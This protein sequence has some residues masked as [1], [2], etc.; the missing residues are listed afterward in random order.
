MA[1]PT[2]SSLAQK[3][4]VIH[5]QKKGLCPAA[6]RHASM[7]LASCTAQN[8]QGRAVPLMAEPEAGATRCSLVSAAKIIAVIVQWP[9]HVRLLSDPLDCSPPGSSDNGI[10]Q[11]RILEW[12]AISFSRDLPDPGMEP[13]FPALAGS[14]FT[15]K[16][17]GR[18]CRQG[19]TCTVRMCKSR[20]Y[21][22]NKNKDDQNGVRPHLKRGQRRERDGG[23]FMFQAGQLVEMRRCPPA[24][25]RPLL[26]PP[27]IC[28]CQHPA[29]L[30]RLQNCGCLESNQGTP[31]AELQREE[32]WSGQRGQTEGEGG[33]P[34]MHR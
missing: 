16:P 22:Y 7:T 2:K 17:P 32:G 11:A 19:Y 3:G 27:A 6:H 24:V 33:S 34:G 1:C 5:S 25:S 4:K 29:W 8:H 18:P 31:G 20:F 21:R 9:S 26:T 10:S 15:T 28:L 14:F 13:V 23:F 30:A 12:V